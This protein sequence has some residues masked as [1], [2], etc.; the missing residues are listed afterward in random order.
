MQAIASLVRDKRM[1]RLADEDETS[2]IRRA[3]GGDRTAFA[4]LIDRHYA[5]IHRFAYQWT[6]HGADAEDIAQEVCIKLATALKSFDGRARFTSWLYRIVLNAVR[7]MQRQRG[8]QTRRVNA[9]ALVSP[10]MHEPDQEDSVASADLWAAIRKLP[11]REAEA[12]LLVY[13]QDMGHAEAGEVMGV[14]ANTVAWYVHEAKKKLRKL[15]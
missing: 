14:S 4:Q 1:G 15:V 11:G 7:D 10:D 5:T 13:G 9:L 12:M 8:R 6:G 3:Q 2:L